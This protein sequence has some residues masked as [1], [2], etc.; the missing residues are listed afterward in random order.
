M[1][2]S[3]TEQ[4][5]LS[6]GAWDRCFEQ[7]ASRVSLEELQRLGQRITGC[8][9][10]SE[11]AVQDALI[12]LWRSGEN[13]PD[14]F[15]AWLAHAVMHRSLHVRRTE[16]RRVKHEA[17]AAARRGRNSELGPEDSFAVAEFRERVERLLHELPEPYAELLHL[18]YIEDADYAAIA[19][20]LALPIGTVRSRLSRGRLLL[21]ER[22]GSLGYDVHCQIC[23]E[24]HRN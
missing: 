3:S 2:S 6:E 22:L 8:V 12:R 14:N 5:R 1:K 10:L 18:R 23:H 11:D 15:M 7:R 21:Q 20:E 19:E 24:S 4:S 9:A 17:V 16:K 13:P